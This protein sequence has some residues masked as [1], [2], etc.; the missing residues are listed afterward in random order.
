MDAQSPGYFL[1]IEASEIVRKLWFFEAPDNDEATLIAERR[2]CGLVLDEND[3]VLLWRAQSKP[4][5]LN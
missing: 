4:V 1:T 5:L 2:L 3:K